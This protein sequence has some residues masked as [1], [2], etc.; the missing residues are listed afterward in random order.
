MDVMSTSGFKKFGMFK[1]KIW[2]ESLARYLP[3]YGMY[4]ITSQAIWRRIQHLY[5]VKEG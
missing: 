1:G 4:D 5:L 2:H 3:T